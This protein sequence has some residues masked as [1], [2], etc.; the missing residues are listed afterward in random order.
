MSGSAMSSVF[1]MHCGT[2]GENIAGQSPEDAA[3]KF[4]EHRRAQH[5]AEGDRAVAT[6]VEITGSTRSLSQI[7]I[8]GTWSGGA[9]LRLRWSVGEPIAYAPRHWEVE[10]IH[11]NDALKERLE[12][13]TADLFFVLLG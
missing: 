5:P 10:T 7:V 11:S 6:I 12:A 9:I 1:T 13:L 2:C 3:N 8:E 4:G